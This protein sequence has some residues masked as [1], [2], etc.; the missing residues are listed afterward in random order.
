MK[1]PISKTTLKMTPFSRGAVT[2]HALLTAPDGHL[3][4]SIKLDA[5]K[6]VDIGCTANANGRGLKPGMSCLLLAMN[7][8]W[9]LQQTSHKS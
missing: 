2:Q 9:Q 8:S 5:P 6:R 1:I 7:G 4:H 3:L